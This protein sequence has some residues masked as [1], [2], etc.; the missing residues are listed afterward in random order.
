[1]YYTR[2]D[3]CHYKRVTLSPSF[4]FVPRFHGGVRSVQV[5]QQSVPAARGG[6]FSGDGVDPK[7]AFHSAGPC[8]LGAHQRQALLRRFKVLKRTKCESSGVGV[9]IIRDAG[10]EC[11]LVWVPTE[12]VTWPIANRK[13]KEESNRERSRERERDGKW[14]KC[15]GVVM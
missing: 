3:K 13:K 8:E 15:A 2:I 7:G 9:R 1:L 14:V 11:W 12:R 10:G 5:S 6:N 4:F